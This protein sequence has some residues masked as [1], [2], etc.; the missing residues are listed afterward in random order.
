MGDPN[1]TL[2]LRRSHPACQPSRPHWLFAIHEKK[3][4]N[5]LRSFQAKHHIRNFVVS[6]V[7]IFLICILP[8]DGQ[9]YSFRSLTPS[10]QLTPSNIK[11]KSDASEKEQAPFQTPAIVSYPDANV[12]QE[13]IGDNDD[14]PF[15][16]LHVGPPKTATTTLQTELTNEMEMLALDDFTYGGQ[17]M[18]DPDNMWKHWK[19][20]LLKQLTD[21][22]CQKAVH[23]ARINDRPWPGCWKQFLKMLNIR[24]KQGYH[25]ILSDETLSMKYQSFG[26]DVGRTSIDWPSLKMALEDQGWRPLVIVGYR[27]L[28]EV[29]PSAKQQWDRWTHAGNRGL[30]LWPPEGRTLQPLFPEVLNDPR[31]YDGYVPRFIARTIQWSYTDHLIEMISPYFEVRLLNMH[32]DLSIRSTLL[33]RVLPYAPRACRQSLLDDQRSNELHKNTEQSLFYDAITTEAADRGWI[34]KTIFSRHMVDLVVREYFE[35]ELGR[36]PMADLP[37]LCP[38]NSQLIKLLERSLVKERQILTPTVAETMKEQHEADFW[39]AAA[40]KKFCWVDVNATLA[41]PHWRQFF[42]ELVPA[43]IEDSYRYSEDESEDES[44]DDESEDASKDED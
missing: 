8:W 41:D 33:C 2:A 26:H 38:P 11:I 31:L 3:H 40:K 43:N 14:R 13:S 23:S 32:D 25:L 35:D 1:T 37:L 42:S 21:A 22:K 34:D 5:M 44:Y 4:F 20:V 7:L 16:V 12:T 9:D 10:L 17:V 24:R 28:F 6:L 29:M 30:T 19:G 27:R 39:K 15:F 18:L 36:N